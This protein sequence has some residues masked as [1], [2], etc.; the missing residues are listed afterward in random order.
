[1]GPGLTGAPRLERKNR[2]TLA[3]MLVFGAS[4]KLK[5][6]AVPMPQSCK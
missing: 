1:M 4:G 3:L 2:A 6:V 5:A